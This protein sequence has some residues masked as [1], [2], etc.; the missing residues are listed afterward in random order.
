L[1][2]RS[3]LDW[4]IDQYQLERD[5]TTGHPTSNPNRDEDPEYIVRLVKQ[6]I[7]VSLETNRIVGKM[8]KFEIIK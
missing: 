7:T 6:I 8:P 4:V 1:G 5:N 3:A 2:N